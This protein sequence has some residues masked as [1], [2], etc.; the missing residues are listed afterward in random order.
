MVWPKISVIVPAYPGTAVQALAALQAADYPPEWLEV[1][2]VEGN[3]P[4]RQRNAAARRAGGD[5]LYFLDDDSLVAPDALQRLAAHYRAS[6][7][8]VVGGPSLAPDDEPLLSRCVGYALGTRLGAWTM[9]ARYASVGRCR[10]ATEK[11]LIGCNLSVRRD[12]F[13]AAGG[14][15][16]DLFPNEET[17]LISRLRRCG[18][19][20]VYDPELVVRRTQRRSLP[21]LVRQFFS[22]GRGRMRQIVRTFPHSGLV[23]LA[24][25]VGLMYLASSLVLWWGLGPWI[26]LP[27][28]AY[29]VLVISVSVYLGV[30]H[31]AAAC[32][33]ILPVIFGIIHACYG[34]G[35]VYEVIVQWAQFVGR[36]LDT[37]QPSQVAT[38]LPEATSLE[39]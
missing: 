7:T 10:P 8:H 14:F 12:V 23:F 19:T 39:K 27:V 34:C 22:Y 17:E 36:V 6:G 29:L 3:R 21:A 30:L 35:L 1:L 4:P 37:G 13:W 26:A 32:S 33:A 2:V 25:A 16:E 15:R 9:R 38:Q 31:Q 5:V 18:C 11:E 28:A 24:P 20:A